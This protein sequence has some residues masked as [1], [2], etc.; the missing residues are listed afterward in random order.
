MRKTELHPITCKIIVLFEYNSGELNYRNNDSAYII[1][2]D[3]KLTNTQIWCLEYLK[4]SKSANILPKECI[5]IVS[6]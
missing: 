3:Y 6:N 4:I 2:L 1:S 5:K